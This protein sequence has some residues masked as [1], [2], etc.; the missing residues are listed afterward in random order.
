M[1][2]YFLLLLFK[3]ERD[4]NKFL[5][6]QGKL[7]KKPCLKYTVC[8]EQN[9]NAESSSKTLSSFSSSFFKQKTAYEMLRSLVGSEMC[10]R[11]RMCFARKF[12]FLAKL[13]CVLQ[14][15]FWKKPLKWTKRPPKRPSNI[16]SFL[17]TCLI[18]ASWQ[19]QNR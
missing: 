19:L 12:C 8:P 11:D 3:T 18:L 7:Y 17:A 5:L 14:E 13:W 1:L 4:W 16:F 9:G 10:I 6:R 2:H 15:K